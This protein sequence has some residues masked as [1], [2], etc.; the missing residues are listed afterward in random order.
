MHAKSKLRVITVKLG[1]VLTQMTARIKLS[2]AVTV[3]PGKVAA[4]IIRAQGNK[5]VLNR[6]GIAGGTNS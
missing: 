5:S 2:P 1:F 3:N 6:P 4:I